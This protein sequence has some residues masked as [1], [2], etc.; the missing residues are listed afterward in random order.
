MEIDAKTWDAYV[1]RHGPRSGRFLQSSKWRTQFSH[2][3]IVVKK[4]D[5]GEIILLAQGEKQSIAPF[6]S[7]IYFPKG[8]I[9]SQ[10]NALDLLEADEECSGE[11]FVRMEPNKQPS[12]TLPVHASHSIQPA[13]TLITDLRSSEEL[14]LAGM[15]EKTRYN[16]RLAKK[17]GVEIEIGSAAFEQAWSVFEMTATRDQFRLHTKAHYKKMI[18]DGTAFLAIAKYEQDILAANIMVDFGDTRTYL[19]GASSNIKR[20]MMAPYLLH[21]ELMM[22]AKT[23]GIHFYDWWGVAPMN[24]PENHPWAGISRFKRGFG[25]EEVESPGTMDLIQ[26]PLVYRTYQIVRVIKKWIAK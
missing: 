5:Q 11:T 3:V 9:M 26:K 17:K 20:N 21:W 23:H 22:D 7:Y 2:P 25:G 4:N 14:L 19:H 16:I 18:E 6:G 10:A 12:K 1:L 15:H 13:H 24:A 8:P